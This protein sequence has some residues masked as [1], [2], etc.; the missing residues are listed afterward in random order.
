MYLAT[1]QWVVDDFAS[2]DTA[3]AGAS[4]PYGR[5]LSLAW[6]IEEFGSRSS[7]SANDFTHKRPVFGLGGYHI[8]HNREQRHRLGSIFRARMRKPVCQILRKNRVIIPMVPVFQTEGLALTNERFKHF[9]GDE[10]R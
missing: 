8:Q 5:Y 10:S 9:K 4:F 3:L 7:H 1:N 6:F 2:Y